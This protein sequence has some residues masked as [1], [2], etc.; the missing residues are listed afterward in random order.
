MVLSFSGNDGARSANTILWP[1][2]HDSVICVGASSALGHPMELSA[3]GKEIDFLCPGEKVQSTGKI[4][5]T[6]RVCLLLAIFLSS[7]DFIYDRVGFTPN[8]KICR[9]KIAGAQIILKSYKCKR[10]LMYFLCYDDYPSY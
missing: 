3:V 9:N 10:T 7:S 5:R 8:W 6:V 2:K 1:G 4:L